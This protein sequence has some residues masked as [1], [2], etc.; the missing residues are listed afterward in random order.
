[1]ELPPKIKSEI[2]A[3]FHEAQN[4]RGSLSTDRTA[5]MVDGSI[6]YGCYISPN[7]DV[8]M[9]TY[10]IATDEPPT[11]DRSYAA[12]IR[13]FILGSRTL[14]ELAE[15]IPPRPSEA[16]DCSACNGSGRTHLEFSRVFGNG[17]DGFLCEVCFGLGWTIRSP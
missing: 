2:Q 3:R 11:V 16:D 5:V 15:L 8:F 10:D 9:E 1:M 17:W 7:G 13:V 4:A 12:Q 14:P 6:G